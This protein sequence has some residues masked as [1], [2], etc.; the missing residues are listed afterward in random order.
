[1]SDLL[2]KVHAQEVRGLVDRL[3]EI[4][5]D[6]YVELPQIAVMG[7]TSSG[8]S[9]LLSALSGVSFPSSDQLTTR[10]PTQLILSRGDAFRGNVR[11]VRYQRS[12][13]DND[14]DS[15]G[16]C[17]KDNQASAREREE[18]HSMDDVPAAIEK[19]TR[20]LVEEG[21]YISD[22]QIVIEMCGPELPNL[23]LTDLPGLVRTVGDNEDQSIIARVRQLVDRYMR[24]ERTIIIAVVP[25]NVD[26]HNTEILQAAQEADPKGVRT[27]AV[28]TKLD[29]VD[30]GAERAVHDLLLNKKKFMHLGYHAVK[31][32]SQR[33]LNNGVSISH[34]IASERAFFGQHEYWR[35]LPQG[36][37]GMGPL[38]KRLV[39]ILQDNIRRSLPKVVHEIDTRMG[40]ALSSLK[41]LGTALETPEARRFQFSACLKK[42][43]RYMDAAISGDYNALPGSEQTA[44]DEGSAAVDTKLRAVLRFKEEDFQRAIDATKTKRWE[45]DR[46]K[47]SARAGAAVEVRANGGA[48]TETKVLERKGLEVRCEANPSVWL[49]SPS[50]RLAQY[51]IFKQFI[52]ENRGEELAIFPS[53][54]VFCNLF[55]SWVEDWRP[56][57]AALLKDYRVHVKLVSDRMIEEVHAPSRVEQFL[58]ATAGEVLARLAESAERLLEDLLHIELSPYTQDASLFQD[59]DKRRVGM[60]KEQLEGL[61]VADDEG[62]VLLTAVLSSFAQLVNANAEREAREMEAVLHAYVEVAIRRFVDLVPMH[63]NDGLLSRF[64]REMEHELMKT[65]DERLE[66]LLQDSEQKRTA[67]EQLAAEIKC[68]KSAKDEIEM[69]AA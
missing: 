53:Y 61:L 41:A 51:E 40:V 7:D 63:L 21:Q 57:A 11:L 3:R 31:C 15:R 1:M 69:L 10:C 52:Q 49:P 29:L 68:L 26:M 37:W 14:S 39:E 8:K 47:S 48:W 32:R 38:S 55:R 12:R 42:Y 4:G 34:G 67:R 44:A 64:A 16:Q 22:D 45:C 50:W 6:Q 66:R 23:T 28:V 36:I 20:K 54:R 35:R 9:S 5:L 25:A 56:P 59:V 30:A 17:D 13:S 58:R 60:L 27:I 46:M 43:L 62:N 2:A 33:D 65:T 19:F 24:Q 18:L